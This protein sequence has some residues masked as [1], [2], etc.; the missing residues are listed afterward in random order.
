MIMTE[1]KRKMNELLSEAV[2]KLQ[3]IRMDVKAIF[4]LFSRDPNA[5]E[6]AKEISRM[7]A[8]VQARLTD[9]MAAPEYASFVPD[10]YPDCD[11]STE[12]IQKGDGYIEF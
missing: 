8:L 2:D 10:E 9:H 6:D 4:T 12:E 5:G 3:D 11:W 7:L 1:T